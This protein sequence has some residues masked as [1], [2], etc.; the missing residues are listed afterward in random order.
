MYTVQNVAVTPNEKRHKKY[1]SPVSLEK[2]RIRQAEY[3]ANKQYDYTGL[4]KRANHMKRVRALMLLGGKCNHCG[5]NDMRVLDFDHVNDDG[6][7]DRKKH[8][9]SLNP[10]RVFENP[11]M[12]QILCA[13]CNRIKRLENLDNSHLAEN[14]NSK[15]VS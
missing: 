4:S 12:F 1:Q 9:K 6:S 15:K 3:R 10:K 7:E 11:E 5:I 14:F 13:N 2:D 8:G